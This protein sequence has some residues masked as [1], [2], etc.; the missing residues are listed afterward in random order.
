[1]RAIKKNKKNYLS[2]TFYRYDNYKYL[3]DKKHL[4]AKKGF[5]SHDSSQQQI[6]IR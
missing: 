1:M 2:L 3:Y 5:H 4:G 6:T